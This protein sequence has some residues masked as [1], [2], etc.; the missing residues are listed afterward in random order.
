VTA[1]DDSA[2]LD[3]LGNQLGAVLVQLATV[4]TKVDGMRDEMVRQGAGHADHEARLRLHGDRLSAVPGL[5]DDV[6][7]LRVDVE[8]L[9][10]WRW[11]TAGISAG[12]ATLGGAVVAAV[13]RAM[14]HG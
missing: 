1:Q 3:Q 6:R 5:I 9:K 2:K 13:L 12:S 7:V 14:G 4:A 8:D 11:S 10:R